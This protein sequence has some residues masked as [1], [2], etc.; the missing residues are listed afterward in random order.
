MFIRMIGSLASLVEALT[1]AMYVIGFLCRTKCICIRAC[2]LDNFFCSC[3]HAWR[4][5]ERASLVVQ[6]SASPAPTGAGTN[7]AVYNQGM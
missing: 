4:C 3:L 5:T 6:A 2:N 1:G 7:H